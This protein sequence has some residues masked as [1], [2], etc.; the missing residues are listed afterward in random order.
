MQ[1]YEISRQ[2]AVS[3]RQSG[4]TLSEMKFL[5]FFIVLTPNLQAMNQLR[6]SLSLLFIL[7]FGFCWTQIEI[8]ND[9]LKKPDE[10]VV[11]VGMRQT[12]TVTGVSG[13]V[14]LRSR[15]MR[16]DAISTSN[17]FRVDPE[18]MCLD[19]IS[20][21]SEGTI[22]ARIPVSVKY[23]PEVKVLIAGVLKRHATLQTILAQPKLSVYWECCQAQKSIVISR[24]ELEVY[25]SSTTLK[26][27]G[28]TEGSMLT[29]DQ[30]AF[31]KELRKGDTIYVAANVR[32]PD[33][34]DR[35]MVCRVEIL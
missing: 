25:R 34:S 10:Q 15:T 32:F 30:I 16:F 35:R 26:S 33:S 12:L 17:S 8:F 21:I 4:G 22:I 5:Q 24:F 2:W 9:A 1:R 29:S 31:I 27:W 28:Y 6:F 23:L 11:Y 7:N 14:T 19:T 20:V 18:R 13:P 3:S